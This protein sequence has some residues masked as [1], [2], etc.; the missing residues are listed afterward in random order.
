MNWSR[1]VVREWQRYRLRLNALR[2]GIIRI[3]ASAFPMAEFDHKGSDIIS[4]CRNCCSI[5]STVDGIKDVV[6]PIVALL[7]VPSE[8]VLKE[9]VREHACVFRGL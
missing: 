7:N 6:G 1:Q 5:D 8:F 9:F 2:A 4:E 3:A